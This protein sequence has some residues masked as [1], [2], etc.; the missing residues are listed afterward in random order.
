MLFVTDSKWTANI[1][2]KMANLDDIVTVQ[3]N[4]VVAVNSL[5]QSLTQF[6]DIYESFV[7]TNSFT[8]IESDSLIYSGVGR[9]V[10]INVV[11]AASGGTIHDASTVAN[12]A[13]SN[14]I[15]LIPSTTGI[16][17]INFPFSN[18][19]VVKPAA[20]SRVS[21]SYTPE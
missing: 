10:N 11:A 3:K 5:V 12:A 2:G 14:V 4:G 7:G 15:C 16:Y 1:E 13:N 17:T 6:K 21:V 18:G 19:L 8:G 9:V 20:T